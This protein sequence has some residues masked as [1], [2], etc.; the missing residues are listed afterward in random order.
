MHHTTIILSNYHTTHYITGVRRHQA[1]GGKLHGRIQRVSV[2]IWTDR[3]VCVVIVRL[4]IVMSEVCTIAC[5]LDRRLSDLQTFTH[6]QP[7]IEFHTTHSHCTITVLCTT[8]Y[9]YYLYYHYC[10]YTG[11]GK[12]F[13][14]TG[15]PALPGLT[16]KAIDELYRYV[17]YSMCIV[18]SACSSA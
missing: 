16:P 15:S 13:T 9:H 5:N 11:S 8:Y 12:T 2:C 18:D 1:T 14:M 3:Y 6:D 17:L 4:V 7:I 10:Y